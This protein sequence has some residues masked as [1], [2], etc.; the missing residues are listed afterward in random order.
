MLNSFQ[1]FGIY[2]LSD[3]LWKRVQPTWTR[4]RTR[5]PNISLLD[6]HQL[7]Q[8]L[9]NSNWTNQSWWWLLSWNMSTRDRGRVQ[10]YLYFLFLKKILHQVWRKKMINLSGHLR[11]DEYCGPRALRSSRSSLYSWGQ[12]KETFQETSEYLNGEINS[13][14]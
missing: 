11:K 3:I 8:I 9:P 10:G 7:V 5:T 4:N 14:F 13:I 1:P 6:N 12:D 2:D